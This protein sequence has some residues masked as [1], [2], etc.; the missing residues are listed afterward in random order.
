MIRTE[1]E[2]SNL[3]FGKSSKKSLSHINYLLDG[4]FLREER[5]F[6]SY[7]LKTLDFNYDLRLNFLK[8][9][10]D[11]SIHT[12]P[13]EDVI[14]LLSEMR[15]YFNDKKILSLLKTLY[16]RTGMSHIDIS[17]YVISDIISQLKL[18][19]ESDKYEFAIKEVKKHRKDIK[20]I[21]LLHEFLSNRIIRYIEQKDFPLEQDNIYFLESFSFKD[22]NLY[23]P[24]T[25]HELISIGDELDICVGDGYYS[26]SIK[27]KEI[28][29]ITLKSNDTHIYCIEWNILYKSIIQCN[30]EKNKEMDP[31]L[32]RELKDF[33]IKKLEE[34]NV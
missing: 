15:T 10:K 17:E 6:W 31:E 1:K 29:I 3:I 2:L 19:K 32:K 11:Y 28:F 7:Y 4:I 12:V 33:I 23:V 22:L 16:L 27:N 5:L 9:I 25:N 30:T 20:D 14:D 8:D 13:E 34:G 26:E 18:I 21:K 24:K